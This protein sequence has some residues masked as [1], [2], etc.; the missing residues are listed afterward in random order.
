RV[1]APLESAYRFVSNLEHLP[2]IARQRPRVLR[3]DPPNLISWASAP[4]RRVRHAGIARFWPEGASTRIGLRVAYRPAGGAL[5]YF[6]AVLARRQRRRQL[7]EDLRR[8]KVSLERDARRLAG[9]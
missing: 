5:G 9:A 1:E 8:L 3:L 4:R 2:A 6:L 7:E